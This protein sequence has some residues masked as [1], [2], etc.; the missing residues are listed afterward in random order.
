MR[1]KRNW[2]LITVLWLIPVASI[3]ALDTSHTGYS[4]DFSK[5]YPN[6][7]DSLAI[8]M[9]MRAALDQAE[10]VTYRS[11]EEEDLQLWIF[12]PHNPASETVP[13][14][15]FIHG[16]GWNHGHA[17]YFAP[18]AI[19][20][21]QRGMVAVT[22]NYRLRKNLTDNLPESTTKQ[23]ESYHE[24]CVRD[25]KSALRWLRGHASQYHIDPD[26]IVVCGGSAGG[27]IAA[28]LSTMDSF[29]NPEDNLAI[30]PAPNAV[31]LFNPALD[32]VENELGQNIGRQQTERLGV[33]IESL[34]PA[35]LVDTQTPPTLILSGEHDPLI[36]PVLVH[37]YLDRMKHHGRPARYIEYLGEDHGFFNF[38]PA[39]NPNFASILEEMDRYLVDLNYLAGS[40]KV[41]D[42]VPWY[43]EAPKVKRH[44]NEN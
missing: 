41:R 12:E 35:H 8:K 4:F 40:P 34:S 16:G 10:A 29:N 28:C 21:A 39:R 9:D 14:I 42:L 19:Y 5:N 23:S 7:E 33:P 18:Q 15:V 38:W 11:T 1:K 20:F 25:G 44:S 22:I 36:P 24:D 26:R 31:I 37:K 43:E 6:P 30:S 27:H 17:A 32:F 13:A 3:L 2:I